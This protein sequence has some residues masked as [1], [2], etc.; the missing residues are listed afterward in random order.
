MKIFNIDFDQIQF[1]LNWASAT[2]MV[3]LIA[4]IITLYVDNKS[5][6]GKIDDLTTNNTSL[7]V[8]VQTMGETVNILK[9]SENVMSN[10]ITI[11]MEN[12]PAELKTRIETM[13]NI[14]KNRF[15]IDVNNTQ[16]VVAT[17]PA[18]IDNK[19]K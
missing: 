5:L 8:K 10:A 7:T 4:G 16:A 12:S 6:Q 15:G 14:F 17:Q 19:P 13:E 3:G 2:A 11:F 1:K 9:G 18:F